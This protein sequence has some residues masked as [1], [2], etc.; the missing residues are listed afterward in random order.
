MREKV[1]NISGNNRS[2]P[3]VQSGTLAKKSWLVRTTLTE[4]G[5]QTWKYQVA[6]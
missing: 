2:T 5:R 3:I 4:M 6:P 1:K